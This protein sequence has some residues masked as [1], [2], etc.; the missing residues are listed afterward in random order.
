MGVV[1]NAVNNC[2]KIVFNGGEALQGKVQTSGFVN[3]HEGAKYN[4]GKG[5]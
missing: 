1:T 3:L 4:L 2:N 5:G